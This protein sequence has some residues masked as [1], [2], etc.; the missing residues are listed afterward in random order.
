MAYASEDTAVGDPGAFAS[1]EIGTMGLRH[2]RSHIGPGATRSAIA[3][4][5]TI[6]ALESELD[7]KPRVW[8]VTT[9]F[10]V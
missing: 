3:A 8:V 9:R 6:R 7:L 1:V 2:K 5:K 10:Y 4:V